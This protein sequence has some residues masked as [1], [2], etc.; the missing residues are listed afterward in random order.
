MSYLQ[1]IPFSHVNLQDHF[2]DSL[3]NGYGQTGFNSWY[4]KKAQQGT[5]AYVLY[6][7]KQEIDVF[8][9]LK[10]EN[11]NED[12]SNIHPPFLP[13][14]RL[15]VGTLKANPHGTK[16][17][18]RIIKKIMD[19]ALEEGVDEIYIT[20]FSKTH[21]DLVRLLSRFG[22]TRWGDQTD[23]GECI[24]IKKL[25]TVTGS[26]Y[27]DYP[28][29]NLEGARFW[30]LAI[31]PEFHTRMFPDSILNNESYD[32]LR[33]T[34]E[35]NTV[36][37]IYLAKMD[38]I[39]HMSPGDVVLIYRTGDG[40]APARFRAVVT[41]ICVVEEIR[42]IAQF[43]SEEMFMKYCHKGSVFTDKELQYFY[44]TKKY[45]N[46]IKMTYNLALKK[47]VTNGTLIDQVGLNPN[48]WGCFHITSLQLQSIL[49]LGQA[50]ERLLMNKGW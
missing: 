22:F 5:H 1:Y 34:A 33:D 8:L 43:S 11:K 41:S 13:K 31:Y 16:L 10:V 27:R 38:C 17:G 37:K 4:E 32:L 21:P 24:Y 26:R 3:R 35:S 6:N 48:Y 44:R 28:A 9:Y 12:Y 39:T 19:H 7:D 42:D 14:R 50:N 30:V 20:V 46:I 2:F 18:E 36:S 15:K 47:R 23:T 29:I 25:P 40:L 49:H 45:P